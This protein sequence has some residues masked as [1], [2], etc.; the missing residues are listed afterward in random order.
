MRYADPSPGSRKIEAFVALS[1]WCIMNPKRLGI[2][3]RDVKSADE[4][5]EFM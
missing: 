5:I 2:V 4:L 1:C 3:L